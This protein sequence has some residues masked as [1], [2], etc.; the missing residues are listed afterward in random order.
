MTSICGSLAL[1]FD[2]WPCISIG[3]KKNHKRI[4]AI[5]YYLILL[6]VNIPETQTCSDCRNSSGV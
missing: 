5:G 1:N 3:G 6:S 2:P 4:D